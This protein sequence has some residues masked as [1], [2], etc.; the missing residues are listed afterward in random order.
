MPLIEDVSAVL[1]I[2]EQPLRRLDV[3]TE[4]IPVDWI[5]SAAALSTQ[6]SSSLSQA[7]QRLGQP[8]VKWHGLQ[9]CRRWC[10]WSP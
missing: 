10:V 6:A 7:P 1:T 8:P 9:I 4:H 3:L 5:Q 2:A